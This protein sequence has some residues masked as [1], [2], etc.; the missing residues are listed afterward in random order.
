MKEQW[1]DYFTDALQYKK[2]ARI[3]S[4]RNVSEGDF[5]KILESSIRSESA[6]FFF[7]NL[8]FEIGTYGSSYHTYLP[9][10]DCNGGPFDPRV[11]RS[12]R[13]GPVSGFLTHDQDID[14]KYFRKL[15]TGIEFIAYKLCHIIE[16][17]FNY[18]YN[19]ETEKA[20]ARIKKLSKR[21]CELK[22]G[23]DEQ[24]YISNL[25]EVWFVRNSF[26]HSFVDLEI[27]KY[28]GVELRRCFGKSCKGR[29][30]IFNEGFCGN[31]FMNDVHSLL[32][33]LVSLF[34]YYQLEQID[35]NKFFR[36]CDHRLKEKSLTR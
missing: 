31:I 36:L 25:N 23:L 1:F 34:V 12:E 8:F 11:P 35:S 2:R 6:I 22:C 5:L 18:E 24:L 3:S 9:G 21:F 26:A 7:D 29:G 13:K 19:F 20:I 10:S 27:I 14:D 4:A 32:E 28:R 33:P 15:F 30:D 17:N 16:Y